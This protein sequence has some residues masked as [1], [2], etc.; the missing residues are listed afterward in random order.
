MIQKGK[1]TGYYSFNNEQI[2]RIRGFEKTFF[3]IEIMSINEST[4]AG[5]I[6]DDTATGGTEG[7]GEISGKIIHNKIHFVKLM[8]VL[9]LLTDRNGTRK[10]FNKK[11]RPIYYTGQL[12]NDGQTASGTWRFKLGVIWTG[13]FPILVKPSKGT[14]SMMVKK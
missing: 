11:H 12:S 1:W 7:I 8:P 5:K 4:F 3:E 9:T 10:T 2:N 14:W 6:Q 13:I